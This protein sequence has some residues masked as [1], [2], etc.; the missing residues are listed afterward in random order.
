MYGGV[1][2]KLHTFLT[3][4]KEVS[5]TVVGKEVSKMVVGRPTNAS[6]SDTRP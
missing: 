1:E 5:K 3:S 6:G 4:T 2:E